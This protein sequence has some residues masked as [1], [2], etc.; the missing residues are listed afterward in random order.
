MIAYTVDMTKTEIIEGN[1]QPVGA[2]FLFIM[3]FLSMM[4]II[5]KL[6]FRPNKVQ[7]KIKGLSDYSIGVPRQMIFQDSSNVVMDSTSKSAFWSMF[8]WVFGFIITMYYSVLP[9]Y[10]ALKKYNSIK[11][12][13]SFSRA[14]SRL[15]GFFCSLYLPKPFRYILCGGFAKVYGINM[16]EVEHPDFGHYETF[17]LFFTRHLKKGVRTIE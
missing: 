8:Q 5:R 6:C 13:V 10:Q 1:L 4:P 17:T 9:L 2:P 14:V 3:S 12:T 15:T 16:D 11:Y 7:Y